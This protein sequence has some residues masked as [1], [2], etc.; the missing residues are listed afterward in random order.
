MAEN[1]PSPLRGNELQTDS[2]PK[3]RE[4]DGG[5]KEDH[6]V[7]VAKITATQAIVVAII[8]VLGSGLTGYLGYLAAA[9]RNPDNSKQTTVVPPPQDLKTVPKLGESGGQGIETLRDISI[10]DLRAWRQVPESEKNNRYSPV[11]YINYLHIK[12]TRPANVYRAHYATS[13]IAI[14]LRCITHQANILLQATP[15]E[16]SGTS[17]KEYAVEINVENVPVD[18]EFLIVIEGTYWN[19]FQNLQQ[20]SA[21]TYTDQ[22]IDQLQELAVI[23]LLPESKP[24]KNYR[25]WNNPENSNNK[26][27]YR[28]QSK[29][30]PDQHGRFLY[31][32]I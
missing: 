28:E 25:L 8:A 29:F 17:M 22:E 32:S 18:Q 11:N 21:S 20:E 30:Y 31:W 1:E 4:K 7:R 16:H 5:T 6:A 13:G 12:K 14:D 10:F 26:E 3:P 27:V 2:T 23:V 19:S 24:F 9:N 15:I